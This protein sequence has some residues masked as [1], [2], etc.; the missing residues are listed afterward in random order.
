MKVVYKQTRKRKG[1]SLWVYVALIVITTVVLSFTVVPEKKY[2]YEATLNEWGQKFNSLDTVKMAISN[3]DI[4]S[5]T[6]NYVIGIINKIQTDIAAQI[7]PQIE[8]DKKLEK[9]NPSKQDST[10]KKTN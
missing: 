8:A 1:V 7:N 2:K 5:R 6:A 9:P 3:S 10:S 4:P